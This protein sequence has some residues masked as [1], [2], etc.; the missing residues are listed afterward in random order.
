[1]FKLTDVEPRGKYRLWLRY[2]DGSEGEVDLSDKAGKGV[3]QAWDGEPGFDSVR[4]GEH[5]EVVWGTEVDLCGDALYFKL[6]GKR[7]EEVFPALQQSD[8]RA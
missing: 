5:G 2:S 7:P 6:T 1:M 4:L 3:F 8:A